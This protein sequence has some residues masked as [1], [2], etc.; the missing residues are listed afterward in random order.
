MGSVYSIHSQMKFKDKDKAIKILQAKISRGEEEHTDY[1]LDTYRKSENLDINDIDDL[2]AVFIGIGR[3]FDVAND[4]NGWTTYSNGFDAT[5][6]W[7]SVM[8]EMFEE[9]APVLEDGSDL[10]LIVMMEPM[11]WLL[12]MENVFKRNEVMR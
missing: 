10:S 8:M 3:M 2:I 4:D 5:Y 6:G 12:K 1:G 7:E 11:C 9:L